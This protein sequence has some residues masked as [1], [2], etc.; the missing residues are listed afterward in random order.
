L[1]K[2]IQREHD[3]DRQHPHQLA[4]SLGTRG[5]G[6]DRLH[7]R[8]QQ[9][10]AD[11]LHDAERD[12]AAR[13]PGGAAEHGAAEEEAQR[14]HPHSFGPEAFDRPARDR[15]DDRERQQIPGPHPLD[16][17]H[18]RVQ[19]AAEGVERDGDDRRVELGRDR[20]QQDDPGELEERRLEPVGRW[21]RCGRGGLDS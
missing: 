7:D 8:D 20:A 19:V 11:A 14:E 1:T 17:G 9:P 2:K 4:H 13:R 6:E 5:L 18:G 16:R 21:R 3:R 15:Q 12:Q 10:A